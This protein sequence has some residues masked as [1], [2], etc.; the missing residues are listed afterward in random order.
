MHERKKNQNKIKLELTYF[1][2]IERGA[3]G[4]KPTPWYPFTYNPSLELLINK[5]LL[6]KQAEK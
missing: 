4:C 3:A 6:L 2:E 1:L 5:K